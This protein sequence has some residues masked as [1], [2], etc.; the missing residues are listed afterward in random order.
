MGWR[1][2]PAI[3]P[4]VSTLTIGPKTVR[5]AETVQLL[6]VPAANSIRCGS[7]LP[8]SIFPSMTS[9]NRSWSATAVRSLLLRSLLIV[10]PVRQRNWPV[11]CG[12]ALHSHPR[13]TLSE[14]ARTRRMFRP[15][16]NASC[17]RFPVARQL[18]PT[19]PIFLMGRS[20]S[21]FPAGGR[22]TGVSG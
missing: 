8:K 11:G 18:Q 19:F 10:D 15:T 7:L 1:H 3:P 17:K 21:A 20:P 4:A 5:D 2:Q 6:C 13:E 16:W 14:S 12:T 9:A 22:L